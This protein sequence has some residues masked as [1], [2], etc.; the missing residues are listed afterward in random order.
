MVKV[1]LVAPAG[2]TTE[3]GMDTALGTPAD[4]LTVQPPLEAGP[5]NVTVAVV[6]LLPP[7]TVGE[8][9]IAVMESPTTLSV[10]LALDEASDT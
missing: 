1:V 10:L 6:E 2:T 5:D 9:E 7:I 4:R 8:S 3:L